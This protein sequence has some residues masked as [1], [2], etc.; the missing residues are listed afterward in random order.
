[1]DFDHHD[2]LSEDREGA[3]R[4]AK[5]RLTAQSLV[6]CV[7]FAVGQ[8]RDCFIESFAFEQL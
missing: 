8:P 1:M 3:P 7:F 5:D 2:P 6:D 4:T